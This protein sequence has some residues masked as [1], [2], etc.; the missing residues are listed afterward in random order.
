MGRFYI[1]VWALQVIADNH[2]V[3]CEPIISE[4]WLYIAA[5]LVVEYELELHNI[6]K[7]YS[8]YAA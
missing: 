1:T 2:T 7:M 4:L 5:N 6:Y 3:Q 8:V